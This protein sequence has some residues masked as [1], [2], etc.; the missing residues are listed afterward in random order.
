LYNEVIMTKN[1]DIQRLIDLQT[2]LHQFH[3]IQR[4]IHLPGD[5]PR[6][7]TDTEHTYTLA[8]TAWFLAQ[9]FPELDTNVCVRLALVHDLVEIYAGDT[10]AY[11]TSTH[12][13][14]KQDR[15]KAAVERLAQEWRHD[16]PELVQAIGAYETRQTAESCFVYALDK[17]MPP[18]V[19]FMSQGISWKKDRITLGML[20]ANKTPKIQE[21]PQ[22]LEYYTELLV[23]LHQNPAYFHQDS[24]DE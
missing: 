1:P 20:E 24:D 2:L 17:L 21:S 5:T 7:E 3:A 9:Y 4:S 6:P 15:E 23:I 22:V 19:N 8:M 12:M 13:H 11:D 14:T 16:F 10:S 18:I